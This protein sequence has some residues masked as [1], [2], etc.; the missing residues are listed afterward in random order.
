MKAQI[1]FL[2]QYFFIQKGPKFDLVCCLSGLNYYHD[3]YLGKQH[4][5]P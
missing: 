1:I 2:L 3:N 5:S 4:F